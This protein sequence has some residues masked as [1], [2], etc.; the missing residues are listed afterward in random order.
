MRTD[1][2]RRIPIPPHGRVALRRL[3]LDAHALA[4]TA[5][6]AHQTA[7]LHRRVYRIGVFRIHPRVEAI[8][9]VRDETIGVGDTVRVLGAG[10]AAEAEI[11]LRATVNVIERRGVVYRDIVE[12]RDRKV[13]LEYPVLSLVEALIY[14]S[15]ATDQLTAVVLRIDPD[16]MIIDM[17]VAGRK[18]RERTAAVARHHD[19]DV[20]DE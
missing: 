20:H 13:C 7:I 3:R 5:V 1:G 11:V 17:L 14:P 19:V 4:G 16:L 10:G 2:K 8:A 15:V 18:R 12:L 6:E 9:P